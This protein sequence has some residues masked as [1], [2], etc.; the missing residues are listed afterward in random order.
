MFGLGKNDNEQRMWNLAMFGSFLTD[1]E[2]EKA[3]P[4]FFNYNNFDHYWCYYIHHHLKW[5][6][7]E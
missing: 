7:I 1:K 5:I 4:F 6:K 3:S 2:I